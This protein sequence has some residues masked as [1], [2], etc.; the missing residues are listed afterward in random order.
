MVRYRLLLTL[1]TVILYASAC[2]SENAAFIDGALNP[3]SDLDN[4]ESES[5]FSTTTE[6]SSSTD[7]PPKVKTENENTETNTETEE[8]A[9][10]PPVTNRH[11]ST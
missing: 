5:D 10:T 6:T 2:S 7:S 8:Q 4:L 11:C 3:T 9:T 1:L